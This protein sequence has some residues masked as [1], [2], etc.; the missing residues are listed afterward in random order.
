MKR[1]PNKTAVATICYGIGWAQSIK[2]VDH[3]NEHD[4]LHRQNG[5]VVCAG[6]LKD[7]MYDYKYSKWF[8]SQYR[9]MSIEDGSIVFWICT[10][11][12]EYK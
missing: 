5:K 9:G 2:I 12:E 6:M 11:L 1:I 3:E 4:L 8:E 7:L 10:K